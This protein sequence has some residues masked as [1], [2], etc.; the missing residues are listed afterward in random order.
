MHV[1]ALGDI[2]RGHADDGVEL[3]HRRAGGDGA[4][5]DLVAGRH[6]CAHAHGG[7]GQL[8]AKAEVA[9]GDQH[10]VVG[11]QAD[12]G[13]GIHLDLAFDGNQPCCSSSL[14][15]RRWISWVSWS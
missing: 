5:S 1:V 8:L 6:L 10:V 15:L 14:S 11:V 2:A 9:A 7:V 4:G 3:A 12:D 13:I